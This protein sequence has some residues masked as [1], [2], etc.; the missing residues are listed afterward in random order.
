MT[1]PSLGFLQGI[2][3][4]GQAPN[5]SYYSTT[6]IDLKALLS[7]LEWP[8]WYSMC[9]IRDGSSMRHIIHW[10]VFLGINFK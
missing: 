6:L 5:L 1:K 8:D 10:T 9:K 7:T 4:N 2:H 3:D